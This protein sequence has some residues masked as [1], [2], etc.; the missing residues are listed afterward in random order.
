[1]SHT[2]SKATLLDRAICYAVEMHAGQLRKGTSLPY[3][4]HPLEAMNILMAMGADME[5]MA[6]GVLH[7]VVEDTDA[8]EED[9]RR[10][11]GDGVADL[12]MAHTE[13]KSLSWWERKQ[14][15]IREL[16]SADRRVKMLIMADKVANLR[17]MARDYAQVGDDLWNRFNASPDMQS[18]YYSGAQDALAC[19]ADDHMAAPVYWEMVELYKDVF[20]RYYFGGEEKD[21]AG[22]YILQISLH[23]EAYRLDRSVPSWKPVEGRWPGMLTPM[24]RPEAEQLEDDWLRDWDDVIDSDLADRECVLRNNETG[25]VDLL[26]TQGIL[27]L[28]GYDRDPDAQSPSGDGNR[29]FRFS[30]NAENTELFFVCLREKYGSFP[31][32]EAILQNSLGETPAALWFPG[33]CEVWGVQFLSMK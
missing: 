27:L 23:E 6:S 18:R 25:R 13:D 17:S 20:V 32:L 3:I 2:Q 1:M 12:V 14:N 30:L 28:S 4:L 29:R 11:F 10:I 15:A 31:P 7:D 33:L 16:A 21:P 19:M 8:T 9:I 24:N 26:M 22:Q 5:L